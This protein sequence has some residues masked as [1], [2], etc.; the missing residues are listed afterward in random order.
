MK[1]LQMNKVNETC[2]NGHMTSYFPLSPFWI[3]QNDSLSDNS[4]T[5]SYFPPGP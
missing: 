3:A 5:T 2:E 1:I 4:H